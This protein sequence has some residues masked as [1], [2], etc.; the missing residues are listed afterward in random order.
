MHNVIKYLTHRSFSS[1]RN[2]LDT[3]VS[4]RK[5]KPRL[6]LVYPQGIEKEVIVG[7]VVTPKG[8]YPY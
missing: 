8:P 4:T 2:L 7:L 6:P 3:Y 1:F 5:K